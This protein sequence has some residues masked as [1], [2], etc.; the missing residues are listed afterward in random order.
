MRIYPLFV[1]IACV[2]HRI[3]LLKDLSAHHPMLSKI[4]V[5]LNGFIV[6]FEC[7]GQV[8]C[9]STKMHRKVTFKLWKA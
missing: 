5:H 2:V 3:L 6:E 1:C 9:I 7:Y 4:L 8:T